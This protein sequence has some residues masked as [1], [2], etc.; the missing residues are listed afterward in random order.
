[1]NKLILGILTIATLITTNLSANYCLKTSAE[2]NYLK[3]GDSAFFNQNPAS[4][5]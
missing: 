3:T 4:F 1:M 2:P 5:F